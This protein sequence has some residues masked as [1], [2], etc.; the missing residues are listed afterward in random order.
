MTSFLARLFGITSRG[1]RE[2]FNESITLAND[3][4]AIPLMETSLRI[5]SLLQFRS[6]LYKETLTRTH[7]IQFTRICTVGRDQRLNFDKS[8]V[9]PSLKRSST[10]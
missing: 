9:S 2:S 10:I 7:A 8:K 4:I 1:V 5:S 3:Q 6:E